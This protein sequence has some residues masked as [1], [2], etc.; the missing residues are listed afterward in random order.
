[1]QSTHLTRFS[2]GVTI[3]LTALF[4]TAMAQ[5]QVASAMASAGNWLIG[6]VVA[7]AILVI[8][9]A[10]LGIASG[11]ASIGG[12]ILLIGGLAAATH[13]TEIAAL[14]TGG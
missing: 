12:I 13:P 9:I 1:M 14:I 11:R 6:V 3:A 5:A 2:V 7:A 10:C 8:V 4:H